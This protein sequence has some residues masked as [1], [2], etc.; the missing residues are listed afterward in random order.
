M[1]GEKTFFGN[2]ILKKLT[3]VLLWKKH[4]QTP[5]LANTAFGDT[6]WV[7][8]SNVRMNRKGLPYLIKVDWLYKVDSLHEIT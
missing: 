1:K 5:W 3:Y 4:L 6:F 2:L 7:N 8:E